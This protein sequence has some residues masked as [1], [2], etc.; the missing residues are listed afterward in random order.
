MNVSESACAEVEIS[1][2][3][4][5]EVS[6]EAINAARRIGTKFEDRDPKNPKTFMVDFLKQLLLQR[7]K[8]DQQLL[9]EYLGPE[10]AEW[11][12]TLLSS[13]EDG[14]RRLLDVN[15]G[16]VVFTLFCPTNES[17]REIET[18]KWTRDVI[19]HF[20]QLLQSLGKYQVIFYSMFCILSICREQNC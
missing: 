4:D 18:N 1:M 14:K 11:W 8:L 3:T 12:K 20:R 17:F 16:S 13:L 7:E 6:Q 10:T 9:N 2:A 5:P 19:K 15:C